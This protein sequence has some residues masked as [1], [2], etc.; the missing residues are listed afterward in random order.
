MEKLIDAK[1]ETANNSAVTAESN[2]FEAIHGTSHAGDGHPSV[3]GINDNATD[4]AGVGVFGKSQKNDGVLG[5]TNS[6]AKAGVAGVNEVGG[7]GIFGRGSGN[8]IFGVHVGADGAGVVGTSDQNDGVRGFSKSFDHTGVVGTNTIGVGV[9]QV[10]A[11]ATTV[12]GAF[13]NIRTAQGLWERTPLE[14]AC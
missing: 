14:L 5:T 6:P 10:K 13:P 12:F 11:T 2:L 7:N 3:V 9:L 4:T 1:S 8:G